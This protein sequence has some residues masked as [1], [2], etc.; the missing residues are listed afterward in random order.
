MIENPKQFGDI[1][2]ADS[3][4]F[5]P[6][7]TLQAEFIEFDRSF[8]I[9]RSIDFTNYRTCIRDICELYNTKNISLA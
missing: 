8:I 5:A 2:L 1:N 6:R 3:H 9:S 7:E 4:F